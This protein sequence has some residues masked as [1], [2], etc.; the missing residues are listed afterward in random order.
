M[1]AAGLFKLL[2]D[3]LSFANPQILKRF[4]RW[5]EIDQPTNQEGVM[6]SLMLFVVAGTQTLLLH[7]YFLVINSAGLT[8]KNA[9]T[10]MLYEKALTLSSRARAMYTHGEIVNLMAVDGQKIQGKYFK[11]LCLF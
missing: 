1:V 7:Q 2:H 6:L 9:L 10:A 3:V 4:I 5:F 8:V 11:N